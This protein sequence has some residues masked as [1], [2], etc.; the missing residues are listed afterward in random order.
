MVEESPEGGY[1]AEGLGIL[2]FTHAETIETLKTMVVDA[3]RCHFDDD[4]KKRK[5]L[6][7]CTL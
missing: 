6:Y 3:V 5:E 7:G 1:H 2:I 4:E